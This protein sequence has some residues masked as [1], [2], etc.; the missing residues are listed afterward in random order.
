MRVD[1]DVDDIEIFARGQ[2]QIGECFHERAEHL[3]AEHRALLVAHDEHG[4][5]FGLAE[6]VT[7]GER[8][9]VFVAEHPVERHTVPQLLVEARLGSDRRGGGCGGLV[10]GGQHGRSQQDEPREDNTR[11]ASPPQALVW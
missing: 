6:Q 1:A 10:R 3:R 2:A 5:A 7:E 9:V 4:R 8:C 11:E